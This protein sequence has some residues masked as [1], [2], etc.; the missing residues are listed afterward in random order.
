MPAPSA[1]DRPYRP[2]VL[3]FV[4]LSVPLVVAAVFLGEHPG[5]RLANA[6]GA[7]VMLGCAVLLGRGTGR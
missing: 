3:G 7:A 6:A 1:S 5:D 4:L 2:I